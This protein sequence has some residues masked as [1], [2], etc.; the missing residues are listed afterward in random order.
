MLGFKDGFF[1]QLFNPKA[2]L[3][4]LPIATINFEACNIV[5][6]KIL[7]MSLILTILVFGAPV[8]YC[9]LGQFFSSFI[10]NNKTLKI[11]NT[12]MAL[13]LLF[14]AFS[15]FKEHVY[16]VLIGVRDF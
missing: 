10:K 3:T 2:T 4:A 16:D 15:I 6:A 1:I 11:L 12:I 9:L 7:L 13:L 8:S 14:V 5:G